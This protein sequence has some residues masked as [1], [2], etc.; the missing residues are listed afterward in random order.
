MSVQKVFLI[1][2]VFALVI[3]LPQFAS[4]EW[5]FDV[6]KP[7]IS[8]EATCN[9]ETLQNGGT[10]NASKA[11]A[12]I[13]CMDSLSKCALVNQTKIDPPQSP[14][15][16]EEKIRNTTQQHKITATVS[17]GSGNQNSAEFAF[18]FSSTASPLQRI[19]F[20]IEDLLGK[21]R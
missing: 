20:F 1:P 16:S 2:I 10:C 8:V 13:T 11:V 5:V 14:Y 12:K 6:D 9:G 21:L 15:T 17:D 3:A 7:E 4:A 19:L 18:S